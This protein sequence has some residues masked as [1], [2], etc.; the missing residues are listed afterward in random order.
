MPNVIYDAL[1]NGQANTIDPVFGP[2]EW[3]HHHRVHQYR[4]NITR[5]YGGITMN[6]DRDHM[7]VQLRTAP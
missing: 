4:G 5:T 7:N 3:V 1:W 6:I 2:G